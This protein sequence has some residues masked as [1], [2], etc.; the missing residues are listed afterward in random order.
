MANF[1]TLEKNHL[2]VL[3]MVPFEVIAYFTV[4]QLL[5]MLSCFAWTWIP[6]GGVLFPILIMSL[7]PA[8]QYILPHLFKSEYLQ[9]LD[10]AD[11]EE[12]TAL[13]FNLAVKVRSCSACKY[14]GN[15]TY[16]FQSFYFV[17]M[18]KALLFY[19][20]FKFIFL[21]GSRS[22]RPW[23]SGYSRFGSSR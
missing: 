13:P 22:P 23:K 4:F 10:A 3:H 6:I 5:Y 8:R 15:I 2:L 1:R 7:V 9:L 11:Y 20:T 12:A 19:F 21:I 18:T 16:N 14:N 17:S